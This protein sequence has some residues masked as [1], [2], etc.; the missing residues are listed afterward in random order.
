MIYLSREVHFCA[1]HKLYNP[2]WSKEKNE[3]I[4][5]GCANENWHGHNF[6]MVVTIKGKVDPET[7]FVI[8][9]KDLKSV[10]KREI[11]EKVDHKN[12]N[13][14]VDFMAGKMTSCEVLVE[15]FWKILAPAIA[16]IS[17]G[18]AVLHCIKLNE[19]AKNYAEYYGE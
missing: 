5:G 13:L 7:G 3:E 16:K 18:Q 12:L 14:D 19:T 4:F 6:D 11:L 10:I 8:N 2:K 17:D 1:A 9:F 15:E